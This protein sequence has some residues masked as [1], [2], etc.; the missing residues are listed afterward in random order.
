MMRVVAPASVDP[1]DWELPCDVKIGPG[2]MRKGVKLRTLVARMTM[3]HKAATAIFV[4]P[5]LDFNDADVFAQELIEDGWHNDDMQCVESLQRR[6]AAFLRAHAQA[7]DTGFYHGT[8]NALAL[9]KMHGYGIH[10][11]YARDLLATV[12]EDRLYQV[13][14]DEDYAWAGLDPDRKPAATS[15]VVHL[16]GV[17]VS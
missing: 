3:L 15:N 13:A 4:Q 10:S 12:D 7:T 14:E 11:T 5:A 16:V 9:L 6:L 8:I 1:M 2:T 17:N